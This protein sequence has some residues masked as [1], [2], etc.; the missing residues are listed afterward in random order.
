[1][2][3]WQSSVL[4]DNAKQTAQKGGAEILDFW[5]KDFFIPLQSIEK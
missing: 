5:Y 1:M 2:L 4:K 3:F